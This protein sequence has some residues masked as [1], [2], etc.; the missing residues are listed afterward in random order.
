MPPLEQ[1]LKETIFAVVDLETTGLNAEADRVVE[2]AVRRFDPVNGAV[3]TFDSLVNPERPMRGT[4]YHG[5]REEDVQDAPKF[6]ELAPML[7]RMLSNAILATY[8]VDY[9]ASFLRAEFGRLGEDVQLPELC[10]MW[11]KPM[12]QLGPRCGLPNACADLGLVFDGS[13]HLAADDATAAQRLLQRY[14][15]QCDHLNLNTF[16]D[17][18][19]LANHPFLRTLQRPVLPQQPLCDCRHVS[20]STWPVE[21]RTVP[22]AAALKT[23]FDALVGILAD[24]TVTE[25]ELHKMEELQ[26]SLHLTPEQ[27]GALHARAYLCIAT[28]YIGD[29]WLEHAELEKLDHISQSL[30]RLGWAPGGLA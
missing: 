12:L 1:P 28:N 22:P 16:G 17:L 14:L 24:A 11:L 5:I 9:D 2:V 29:D 4:Q 23:Y 13:Q 30:A 19:G 21:Q 3:E 6:R 27:V 8:N 7:R 15:E 10:L 25:A 18:C 20:R 26:Q